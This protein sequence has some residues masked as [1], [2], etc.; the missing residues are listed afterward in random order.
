MANWSNTMLTKAGRELQ[1]KA[2]GGAKMEL[3]CI[4][5]G[6]G[7]H[8][9]PLDVD[10]ITDLL[11]VQ[12]TMGIA[13]KKEQGGILEVA[14]ILDNKNLETGY[15]VSEMGL[16]ARDGDGNEILYAITVDSTPDYLPPKQSGNVISVLLGMRIVVSNME[17]LTINIDSSGAA[18][19]E[20]LNESACILQREYE[21]GVGDIVYDTRLAPGYYLQ[22]VNGG[23]TSDTECDLSGARLNDVISDAGVKWR[24]CRASTIYGELLKND[25]GKGV[26]LGDMPGNA[27]QPE[28]Y[29]WPDGGFTFA[30]KRFASSLLKYDE[31]GNIVLSIGS[32]A[33]G[34]EN[35]DEDDVPVATYDDIQSLLDKF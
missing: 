18:S 27:G 10:S 28:L 1:A 26:T 14:G 9:E 12:C 29:Q 8:P 19:I 3:T 11:N 22:C 17:S 6:S 4:K 30:P 13:Y 31:Q 34:E 5:V 23:T 15:S 21:Y 16:Y 7:I 35:P 33:G 20:M 32:D 25:D 2:I 24:L